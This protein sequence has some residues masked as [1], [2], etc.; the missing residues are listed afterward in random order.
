MNFPAIPLEIRTPIEYS[1]RCGTFLDIIEEGGRTSRALNPCTYF[2]RFDAQFAQLHL[3][4]AQPMLGAK[5][6]SL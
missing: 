6:P 2:D 5:N 4:S 1:R 3:Q